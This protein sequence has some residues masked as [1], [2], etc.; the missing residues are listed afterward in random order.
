[1]AFVVPPRTV[2]PRT[3]VE[4]KNEE[5]HNTGRTNCHNSQIS[6]IWIAHCVL[7]KTIICC[8]ESNLFHNI[9]KQ[10]SR[11]IDFGIFGC[12]SS[13]VAS[14]YFFHDVTPLASI[15]F[16]FMPFLCTFQATMFSNKFLLLVL[17][18]FQYI[19]LSIRTILRN[20][21][22][23]VVSSADIHSKH[24]SSQ[25]AQHVVES[26]GSGQVLTERASHFSVN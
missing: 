23:S 11:F 3:D 15:I 10:P 12:R 6:H 17:K 24:V 21:A 4:G 2:L 26:E 8:R 18:N 13:N 25:G 14:P 20:N 5:E 7:V 19:L 1:M 16:H 22:K 9:A